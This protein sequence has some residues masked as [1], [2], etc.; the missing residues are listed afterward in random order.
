MLDD[1]LRRFHDRGGLI[2]GICNG[3]QVLVRSGLLPGG[4]SPVPGDTGS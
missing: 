2:L 4:S 3:F 1:A